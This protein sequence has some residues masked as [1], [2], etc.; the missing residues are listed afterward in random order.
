MTLFK[1]QATSFIRQ[2]SDE[3]MRAFV[4]RKLNNDVLRNEIL[5]E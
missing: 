5:F 4:E 2:R 3:E 1:K